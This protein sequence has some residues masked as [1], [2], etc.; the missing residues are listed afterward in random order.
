MYANKKQMAKLIERKAIIDVTSTSGFWSWPWRCCCW[1]YTKDSIMHDI[2]PFTMHTYLIIPFPFPFWCTFAS[3]KQVETWSEGLSM[4]NAAIVF[5]RKKIMPCHHRQPR[6]SRWSHQ[7]ANSFDH[8]DAWSVGKPTMDA[9]SSD[10]SK[11]NGCKLGVFCTVELSL[12][13][14]S[15][16]IL[17]H[18]SGQMPQE[19]AEL[20]VQCRQQEP[21]P[22]AKFTET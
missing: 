4:L 21:E 12:D 14:T 1:W 8:G 22:K 20:S 19:S 15:H 17:Q 10:V 5:T 2:F 3:R 6:L 7:P 16:K 11:I 13:T 9:A 18:F